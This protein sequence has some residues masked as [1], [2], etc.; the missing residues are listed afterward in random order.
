MNYRVLPEADGEAIEAALWYEE[1]RPGL[2][3]EFLMELETGLSAIRSSHENLPVL[4]GYS[5]SHSIRRHLLKRFPYV[6]VIACRAT[7]VL[8]VAIA[9]ARRRPYF[10]LDR[11]N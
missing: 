3:D 11:L 7:E 1:R 4:E 6:V 2:G 8:V 10:W 9:H 5:G